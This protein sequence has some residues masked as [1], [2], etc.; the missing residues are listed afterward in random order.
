LGENGLEVAALMTSGQRSTQN[1]QIK[2][3]S[4][5]SVLIKPQYSYYHEGATNARDLTMIERA[6]YDTGFKEHQFQWHLYEKEQIVVKDVKQYIRD[7]V[8]DDKQVALDETKSVSEWIQSLY[9]T[10][11]PTPEQLV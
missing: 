7:T 11:R 5:Y 10:S 9:A 2:G 6:H 1:N 3:Y 4:L 8:A